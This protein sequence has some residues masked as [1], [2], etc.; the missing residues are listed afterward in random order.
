MVE[1]YN[2]R[3]YTLKIPIS[4]VIYKGCG[5]NFIG[6]QNLRVFGILSVSE[7]GSE[8]GLNGK[9]HMADIT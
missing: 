3:L 4:W 1:V 7:N 5:G 8:M 6:I 2:A 9:G